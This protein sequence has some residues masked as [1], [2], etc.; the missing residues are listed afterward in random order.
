M[1]EVNAS[2]DF[3]YQIRPSSSMVHQPCLQ[4]LAIMLKQAGLDHI[5]TTDDRA[6]LLDAI[7]NYSRTA[8]HQ[9]LSLQVFGVNSKKPRTLS[10]LM[11][12][13]AQVERQLQQ[14]CLL[15]EL[16]LAVLLRHFAET[17]GDPAALSRLGDNRAFAT[18]QR[19]MGPTLDY[20][21]MKRTS[22]KT[23]GSEAVGQMARELKG[24]IARA[25]HS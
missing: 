20:F 5:A 19:W 15:A 10:S 12:A 9:A 11:T 17:N 18:L 25:I 2:K 24:Y 8:G 16:L 23:A 4:Q 6:A 14:A 3:R 22:S 21:D 1:W 13:A 7:A